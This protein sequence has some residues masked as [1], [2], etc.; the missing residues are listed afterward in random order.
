M[1]STL[2]FLARWLVDFQSAA[3][4]LLGAA[5]IGV[6]CIRQPALRV[7]LGWSVS[8][9][10]S[11]LLV[12]AALPAWP[13]WHA[14]KQIPPGARQGVAS[15][16]LQSAPS[17]SARISPGEARTHT[18]S[19][20]PRSPPSSGILVRPVNFNSRAASISAVIPWLGRLYM[21]GMAIIGAWLV[22][23]LVES[24][25]ICRRARPAPARLCEELRSVAG[26][27]PLPRLLLSSRLHNAV[28]LGIATPTILLPAALGLSLVTVRPAMASDG[29]DTAKEGSPAANPAM[30][31]TN[32]ESMTGRVIDKMSR[33]PVPGA[34]VRVQCEIYS[35]TEHRVVG[36]TEQSTD[37]DGRFR[38][39]LTPEFAT[40]RSAYLNFEVTHS[41]YA[42]RPWDGYAL[43]MIRKNKAL[44]AP[45]FFES[46]DLTPA[47]SISGSLV[48]PDGSPAGGVKILTYSK[49]SKND[50]AEYGS[51]ADTRTDGAG[52]FQVNVVKGGE[53]VLWL[54]P[55]DFAPSTHLL[56]K[57]RGDLGQFGLEEG[58]RLAG[59]VL[60]S[61]GSPVGPVWVNAE[62]SGGPAKKPIG[63][64]VIDALSRSA[65]TD[66]QGQF[67]LGP[68]PAGDYN[69]L[70][71]EYPR[72]SLTENHARHPV[73]DVFLHQPLH[74]DSGQASATV[75]IRAVPHVLVAMQQLDSQGNPHKT[76]EVHVSGQIGGTAWWGEGRPDDNGKILLEVPRTLVDAR[77]DLSV[78]EH[79]STRYRWSDDSPWSN[80][81]QMRRAVLDQ[82]LQ[83]IS[84]VYY[85][86]PILLVR[87]TAEDGTPV[88][89]F[90]CELA[91]AGDRKPSPEA[92]RWISGIAGD[93]DFEKQPD[94]RWRSESLLP[95]ENL[96]LTVQADGFQ[97]YTQTVNLPEG[98]TREIEARLQKE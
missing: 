6:R 67:A 26:N 4:L 82:D 69:L 85:T 90:K 46:L 12:A 59:R 27:R 75:E 41:N 5:W 18:G 79:Q 51:F 68:L 52:F 28:A 95:D 92:P 9:A 35:S 22:L 72:D 87:A 49:A 55:Q 25:W 94:G 8:L 54:L 50:M 39:G 36:A 53:A 98:A 73:P 80:E 89:A 30:V 47:E 96:L 57:Q 3:T 23:G 7:A 91:Y 45:P 76:H 24:A 16:S 66:N 43:A 19:L 63:M 56:H 77:F 84:V 17:E 31:N 40:N 21:L 70:I 86:A 37:E 65:L 60:S 48:R 78:N 38:F 93:V 34:T 10:L 71:S 44:G 33:E 11:L 97:P 15:E 14:V 64:P 83:D 61:D 62:L 42:R 29:A 13:R 74:L 88:P 81:H 20:I 32:S 1:N 2:D 58:I